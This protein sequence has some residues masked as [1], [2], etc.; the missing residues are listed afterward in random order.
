MDNQAE[1]VDLEL[2][3]WDQ[4][5]YLLLIAVSISLAMFL[6]SVSMALYASSGAAQLDLSRPGYSA[7]TSQVLKNNN[8]FE[9]YSSSGDINK[10]S[11]DEFRVLYERQATKAKAVDA[12]RGDPLNPAALELS[13]PTTE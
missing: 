1:V 7:V 2:S 11:I 6:V 4:H 10:T 12:F 13:L 9:D 3:F 5:R 8:D